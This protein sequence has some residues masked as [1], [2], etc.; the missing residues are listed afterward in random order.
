MICKKCGEEIENGLMYCPKCGESIQLVPDYNVFEEELLIK[1]VEDKDKAKDDKFASGVYKMTEAP[2]ILQETKTQTKPT[3]KYIELLKTV[4]TK[5]ICIIIFC[6]VVCIA[7]IASCMILPYLGTHNYDYAMN[8]AV[9]AENQFQYAKALGY[10]E[11]AYSLDESSFEAIYGLG[12]MYYRIKDYDNAVLMLKKAI[13]LDS[14]NKKI[15][16]YLLSVYDESGDTESIKELA[17][18]PPN[19]E[20]AQLISA[21]IMLPP[22]FSYESGEYDEDLL[23]QLTTNGDYQIF[24]TLNGK[25]PVTS[26]KLYNKPIEL[27]EGTTTIKAATQNKDGEYSEIATAEYTIKHHELSMPV[28][29]PTDGVYSE[30]IMITIDVP[31]GCTA[32]YTWD[33]SDPV[34]N[35]IQY[36]DP[37]PILE[38]ASVL[39]VAIVDEN[40]N[41]SPVYRGNYIYQP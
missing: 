23:V 25:N 7:I 37:F 40:G 18:N 33:G 22:G 35:G 38:G 8:K 24:Y 30:K 19:D 34:E 31:E 4:F 15:Y 32:F 11:E 9:D 26:G 12:R 6:A 10:Y 29:S 20:I 36:M 3:N 39:S 14:T 5:K 21:Y 13:E 17:K 28:V 27:T 2:V 41:A 1:V 16:S